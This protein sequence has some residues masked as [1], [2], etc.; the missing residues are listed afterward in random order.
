[1]A[2]KTSP[3]T[4]TKA[5]TKTAP[6]KSKKIGGE[7]LTKTKA[8]KKVKNKKAVRKT[9]GK[10][11]AKIKKENYLARWTT[12]AFVFTGDE[13]WMYRLSLVA[14]TA[15]SLWSFYK[16]DLMV[17][18]TFGLLALVVAKYLFQK[19]AELE[20]RIDLDGMKISPLKNKKKEIKKSAGEI[21]KKMLSH[22]TREKFYSF[23]EIE[24]FEVTEKGTYPEDSWHNYVLKIKSAGMFFPHMEIPLADQDPVYIRELMVYFVPEKKGE[25][26]SVLGGGSGEEEEYVEVDYSNDKDR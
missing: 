4:K 13:I 12:P 1:M 15:M 25:E 18:A 24:S 26:E 11:I 3:K 7:N 17:G 19:P 23:D 2:I 6:K 8:S 16:K 21:I 5:A 14:A 10:K 20:C 9:T 22:E